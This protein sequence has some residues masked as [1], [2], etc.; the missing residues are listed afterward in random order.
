MSCW[1]DNEFGQ[2]G[3]GGTVKPKN[4]VPPAPQQTGAQDRPTEVPGLTGVS[5]LALGR[6]HACGIIPGGMVSCWGSDDR[7]ALGRGSP[8]NILGP[9]PMRVIHPPPKPAP[10]TSCVPARRS[11]GG[12]SPSAGTTTNRVWT[13]SSHA[14]QRRMGNP[15]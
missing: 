10:E 15:S 12:P 9:Q 14:S 6:D 4:A 11:R 7:Q 13:S 2:L 5:A 1:G 8:P 3:L